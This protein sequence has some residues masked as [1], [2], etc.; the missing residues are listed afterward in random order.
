V[1]ITKI[2]QQG[3]P[4]YSYEGELVYRDEEMA[5]VR[6]IWTGVKP[7]QMGTFILAEGDLFIEYYYAAQWFNFFAVYDAIGRLK[8][9]YCNLTEPPETLA[10]EIRWRDLALDWLALPDGQTALLDEDEF[11]ALRP[12]PEVRRQAAQA[13][14]TLRQW[15]G[16]RRFP[17][18]RGNMPDGARAS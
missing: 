11:E 16:E 6:C 9:W 5:V 17:F 1:R 13:L 10:D 18:G 8:G 14:A 4:P 7:F 12:S 2:A 3:Q 15:H